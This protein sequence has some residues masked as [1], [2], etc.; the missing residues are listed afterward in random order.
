[1]WCWRRM[2]RVSWTEFRTNASI[3]QEL[4]IKQRLS[5][6]VQSRI[7]KLF[8]HISR[9]DND[10]LDRLVVQ[11]KVEGSRPR[12]RS[13]MRWTFQVKAMVGNPVHECTRLTTNRERWRDI[14]ILSCRSAFRHDIE[15]SSSITEFADL[16]IIKNHFI[17]SSFPEVYTAFLLFPSI[18]VTS[19][20]AER[21]FS[22]LKLIKT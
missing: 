15:T 6:L 9:R 1:M 19:A 2:L 13:P 20:S 7:L 12:G 11:G 14:E 4:G 18:P 10:S 17:S 5:T 16:L 3:L 22:K 21:S 8:G